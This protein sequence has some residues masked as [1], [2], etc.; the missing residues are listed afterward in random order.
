MNQPQEQKIYVPKSSAKEIHFERSGKT[1]L[2][3][4]FKVQDL[5][6]FLGQHKNEKGY[7][8][9]GVSPRREVSQYGDTHCVWLDTWKPT[10][11]GQQ[12]LKQSDP[13]LNRPKVEEPGATGQRPEDLDCS[14]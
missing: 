2:K 9:F 12:P 11:G 7:I 4:N 3:L 5:I 1:I 13:R 6:A 8:T 10:Q 14:F